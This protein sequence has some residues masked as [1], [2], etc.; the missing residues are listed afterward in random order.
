[1]IINWLV[2]STPLKD[3]SR[4]GWLFPIYGNIRNVPNHQPD[5]YHKSSR[6]EPCYAPFSTTILDNQMVDDGWFTSFKAIL[7]RLGPCTSQVGIMVQR[8]NMYWVCGAPQRCE[9]WFI[10]PMNAIVIGVIGTINHS[11]IG[12]M[13]IPT[14][15]YPEGPTLW[16]CMW[17]T[18]LHLV[19][20]SVKA[21]RYSTC[22]SQD[23][24][25]V[26]WL[27]YCCLRTLPLL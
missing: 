22:T 2:V 16:V 1:M 27:P 14:E 13:W 8:G 5:K 25:S 12:V 19:M 18:N 17:I 6:H 9:H 11:E 4:L 20:T 15:R 7:R 26:S 10:N 21:Y 3:I 24:L 23:Q